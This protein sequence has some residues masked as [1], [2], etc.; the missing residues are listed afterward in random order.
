MTSD[1]V[2]K[3]ISLGFVAVAVSLMLKKYN[4]ELIPFFEIAVIAAFVFLIKD[5]LTAYSGAYES[6]QRIYQQGA[7]LFECLI[8]AAAVT[9]ITRL[10]SELCRESGN[11]LIG[12]LVELGGRVM[13]TVLSLPFILKVAETALSFVQ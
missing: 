8:K 3:T 2:I 4:K 1:M 6:L 12:E 7:E 11:G 10:T 9:V 13:L 5:S